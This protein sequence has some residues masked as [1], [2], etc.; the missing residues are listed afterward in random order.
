MNN[1]TKE[2]TED[3]THVILTSN[4]F[5]FKMIRN[6]LRPKYLNPDSY[7]VLSNYKKDYLLSSPDIIE[8]YRSD[9]ERRDYWTTNGVTQY[10]QPQGNEMDIKTLVP[11]DFSRNITPFIYD[12]LIWD[13]NLK[14]EFNVKN[15]QINGLNNQSSGTLGHLY[16]ISFADRPNTG[17]QPVDEFVDI[18]INNDDGIVYTAGKLCWEIDYEIDTWK[19]NHAA[20]LKQY[21]AEQL[22]AVASERLSNIDEANL[23]SHADMVAKFDDKPIELTPTDI[24]GWLYAR[25]I[26]STDMDDEDMDA[27]EDQPMVDA[28]RKCLGIQT[29]EEKAINHLAE[30]F[31]VHYEDYD[32]NT[33]LQNSTNVIE[34]IVSGKLPGVKWVG[35]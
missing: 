17:K 29:A 25:F 8:L 11:I 10:A 2:N 9:I 30:W 6:S 23:I 33:N 19:P 28:V 31:A 16:V 24:V 4:G 3:A 35:E 21:Q 34:F 27:G 1:F 22:E 14:K 32:D 12:D 26:Q 5:E 15:S 18:T 20:M 13:D 7:W